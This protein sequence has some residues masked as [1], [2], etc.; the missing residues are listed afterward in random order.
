MTFNRIGTTRLTLRSV[1]PAARAFPRGAGY[2]LVTLLFALLLWG[3][4]AAAQDD[5]APDTTFRADTTGFPDPA[6]FFNRERDD[7]S[8]TAMSDSL[9]RLRDSLRAAGDSLGFLPDSASRFRDIDT[10]WVVYLDSAARIRQLGYHRDD[11][12]VVGA[13]VGDEKSLFLDVKSPA[14][15]RELKIDTTGEFV[16]VTERVNGLDAKVPLTMTLGQYIAL[17]FEN[18]RKKNWRSFMDV[19]KGVAAGDQLGSVLK[20][21]T[22]I[23]IP[24]PANPLFSIFGGKDIKLNVSGAVDIRAG[25]RRTSSDKVT[26]SVLDQVRNEPNFNQDV[27]VNVNGTIGDKLNILADWN[28]QRTFDFENQL[29]IKYTGYDDEIIKSVEAGNVSLRTPA[30]IGG[31]QS[32]FGIKA[33]M[34]MGPLNLTALVSQKKGQTKEL[35]ISGGSESK[36]LTISPERY[37]QSYYFV[38]LVY[39]Q[40]WD[41]L[42]S[43]EVTSISSGVF[44]NEIVQIDVWRSVSQ[45]TPQ[46]QQM[47]REAFA[48]TDIG[49]RPPG[50]YAPTIDSTLSGQGLLVDGKFYSG[51]FIRLDPQR[52]YDVDTR[53]GTIRLESVQDIDAIAVSYRTVSGIIYGG[54]DTT[55]TGK[56]ILKLIKPKNLWNQPSYRPAWDLMLKNIYPL[57]GRDLKKEGFSMNIFRGSSGLAEVDEIVGTPLLKVMGLDRFDQNNQRISDQ[58]FD[59]IPGLSI[60]V[61]HAELIFPTLRPFDNGIRDYFASQVPPVTGIDSLLFPD[62]YDTTQSGAANNTIR[63][64]Y[65]M[66]GVINLGQRSKISLGFNVVEGSVQVLLNGSPMT[67]N[68]DYTVDYILGEVV[69]RSEQATIPS[70]NVEVKYE[71]N[72]LFQLASKT[73]MGA[74][75]EID[76]I[77]NTKLGFTA[78]NLNQ[79]TLSDKVRLGEEPTNNSILGADVSSAFDLPVL[80]SLING[81]P[82][83]RTI[84]SSNMKFSAEAAYMIPDPNTKKSPILSDNGASIAMVD[85]FEGTRRSIPFPIGYGAWTFSSAPALMHSNLGS[86]PDS[87]K[88][89]ARGRLEYFNVLPS[90]VT[91][92]NIWPRRQYRTGEN[93]VTVFNLNFYPT[94]RAMYNY[95]PD[96][97]SSLHRSDPDSVRQNWNGVTRYLG[98]SAGS[99]LEQNMSFL[100]IWMKVDA[101][102]EEDHRKGRL[103]VSLGRVSEDI[104]PNRRLNSEDLIPGPSNPTGFPNGILNP[105]EEDFGI[106]TMSDARE[107]VYYAQFLANNAG[108][109]DVNPLDPSGDN[110]GYVSGSNDFSRIDGVEGNGNSVD[111]RLPDTEDLSGNGIAELDNEYAE[112]EIP[113]DTLFITRAGDLAQNRYISGGGNDGWFQ[114]RIPLLDPDTIAGSAASVQDVLRNVQYVRLWLS[115][116]ADSVKIRIAEMGLVGNQWQERLTND[117]VMNIAVVNIEDN[118][119]YENS[120]GYQNLGIV[121]E[122]DRT[123]PDKVIEGNEQSLAFVLNGLLPGDSRQAVRYFGTARPLNLFNYKTMKMFVYGDP[124]LIDQ[125]TGEP[126]AEIFV[127]FGNDTLNFYEYR[128]PIRA[129]WDSA[130][131][132]NINFEQLTAVKAGRDS[133]NRLAYLDLPSPAGARYGVRGNPSLRQVVEISVGI[134]HRI[135]EGQ[136]GLP[137][138]GEVWINE[139]RLTDV[140]DTP[141]LAFRYDTQIKLADFGTVS[142]NYAR[143]DPTFHALADR[144]GNQTTNINWAVNANL[145]LEDFVPK[146]WKGT[147]IPFAYSHREQIVKPK[148][149]PNTDVVVEEAALIAANLHQDSVDVRRETPDQI[150]RKSQTLRVSDSYSV[151][152]LRIGVPSDAWY[153]TETINRLSFGFN[154]TTSR[155]RD[156]SIEIRSTWAWNASVNYGVSIQPNYFVKPFDNFLGD[157]FLLSGF[158]DWKVHLMP[159]TNLTAG[160]AAQRGRTYEVTRTSNT[161]PRD[162]RTLSANKKAGFAWRLTEGGLFNFAGNYS[163]TTDRNLNDYDN[164]SVGRSFGSLLRSVLFRGTDR[165]YAQGFRVNSKPLIPDIFGIRKSLDLSFNYDANYSWQNAFQKGDIGKSAGVTNRIGFVMNFKLKQY[166]DPW[167]DDPD[168]KK[169]PPGRGAPPKPKPVPVDTSKKDSTGLATAGVPPDSA[170]AGGSDFL[171]SVRNVGRLLVK[172]PI[173]DY[174]NV[175]INFTQTNRSNNPGVVGSTGFRNFWGRL[176]FQGSVAEYGPSRLYQLG[177]LYD[178]SGELDIG[179]Q[180]SFPFVRWSTTRGRR[181][182]NAVLTN[183]FNQ[184]NNVA[185]KTDR[186]L[187]TGAKMSFEWKVG[188]QYARTTRD[189]T[190]PFGNPSTISTTTSGSIERSYLTFPSF[191]FLKLFNTNLESVGKKYEEYQGSMSQ[192][193]A[194]AK[195][196]EEGLEAMPWLH[197]V[198]GQYL[199]RVNWSFRWDGVEKVAGMKSVVE[200]MSIDHAYSSSFRRDFREVVGV[201]EQTDVERIT[202]GFAPLIGVNA[203]FKQ[204]LKGNLTGNVKFNSTTSYDLHLSSTN[205]NITEDLTQDLQVTLGYARSGFSFPLFGV[206]LSNDITVSFSYTISK[207]SQRLHVPNLLTTNQDGNPLSGS[208]RTQMEPRVR[209]VLSSRVTA[210]LYYRFS[211]IAPDAEGSSVIGTTTNEAGL[212]IHISI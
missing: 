173:L 124:L 111:G 83:L 155:D 207:K 149:L 211:S 148:Y 79:A 208:T 17:R 40:F 92:E 177:I 76:V 84:E 192:E 116:F 182:P 110:W 89:W 180:S 56:L 106:D 67:P 114:Y 44:D 27:R 151:P 77:P 104:I 48:H 8:G 147:T 120:P 123:Q 99:I 187:W 117:S 80:T 73:L 93:R 199:P 63:N 6:S 101:A 163:L 171:G 127:R 64:K 34:Q 7:T 66:R 184:A 196:F 53:A 41:D 58:N 137:L 105:S 30:L 19:N 126:R 118:P 55:S 209:Y 14:Y 60:D 10:T 22:N 29:K 161:L 42:H 121:R 136:A 205:R 107:R 169:T 185:I 52:D 95:S 43:S 178:P 194:L 203:T 18:D 25:F 54:D 46:T 87:V 16:T 24:V 143:T 128:A 15:Q 212:D 200:R 61:E 13:F 133:A 35:S 210:A 33:N 91:V 38:D 3:S 142:F 12:P 109:R 175:N 102:N 150:I 125:S 21:L 112:Y 153:V 139:L 179:T 167:F 134:E 138:Y 36:D 74:R 82:G 204:F 190:D 174:D 37:S 158:R 75:G 164:D 157:F 51:Y 69:L 122:K 31:A 181:A 140:D 59:F 20:S 86:V 4:P 9:R 85:D 130:N 176:P 81:V 28:T 154:Y 23:S 72:D 45:V 206:N 57:G 50:G 96:L 168:A 39:T 5:I 132:V 115:G 197:K 183:T 186:P 156:P 129:F 160:V 159:I 11:R 141:G 113:L 189:T 198:F 97:D 90:D 32:L 62:V 108:D 202:F 145:T 119:E 191:L 65:F 135:V 193:A 144:F 100:E 2:Q 165:R 162:T 131:W 1:G 68:V 152:N 172:I 195:A 98:S 170:E 188:W 201:G 166:T 47:A 71:Q 146:S 88:N 70:A 94:R 49:I 26:S 103:H 78:M